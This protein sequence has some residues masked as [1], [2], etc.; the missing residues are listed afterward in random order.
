[1]GRTSA[2]RGVGDTDLV[3]CDTSLVDIPRASEGRLSGCNPPWWGKVIHL[4][5]E[6]SFF[7]RIPT[8]PEAF[9]EMSG[10]SGRRPSAWTHLKMALCHT[11]PFSGACDKYR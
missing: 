5:P 9:L 7:R 6:V 1:M 3:R 4:A 8:G 10:V 2:G 11:R